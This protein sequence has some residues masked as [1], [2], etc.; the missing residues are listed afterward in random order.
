MEAARA[1]DMLLR[2]MLNKIREGH[3]SAW[4]KRRLIKPLRKMLKQPSNKADLLMLGPE[5]EAARAEFE[6]SIKEFCNRC[7]LPHCKGKSPKREAAE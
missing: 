5:V 3:D 7:E 2:G 1:R 4:C 6:A